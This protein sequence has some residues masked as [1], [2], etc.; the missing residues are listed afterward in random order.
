LFRAAFA[1]L[2]ARLRFVLFRDR[3]RRPAFRVPPNGAGSSRFRRGPKRRLRASIAKRESVARLAFAKSATRARLR[4]DARWRR[5]VWLRLRLRR[6][7]AKSRRVAR[8]PAWR[9]LRS[10]FPAP[11]ECARE[12]N[13][14]R[15]PGF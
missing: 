5:R 7:K 2:F 4:K 8:F 15:A 9:G 13:R 14:F 10:V 6:W 3:V 1:P 11:P 12:A